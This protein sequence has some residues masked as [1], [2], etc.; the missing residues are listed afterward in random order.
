[1]ASS[2]WHKDWGVH[3]QP[4]SDGAKE[5][6]Y[7]GAY[8]SRAA[9]SDA[10]IV[11]IGPSSVSFT[12]KDRAHHDVRRTETLNGVEFVRRYL[13]HV[14]PLGLRSIRRYGYCHPAAK[15]TRER[16]AFHTGCPLF[17]AEPAPDPPKSGFSCPCCGTSMKPILRLPRLWTSGRAPPSRNVCVA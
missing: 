1:M 4:F 10:R 14:L 5:I 6:K 8:V 17:L 3:L 11:E 15:V 12:W 7:L 2:V 16:I 9:I 13:R